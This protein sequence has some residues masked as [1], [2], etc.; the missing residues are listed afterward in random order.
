VGL[1]LLAIVV[2]IR[3]PRGLWGWIS[4]KHDLHFFPVQRRLVLPPD[5]GTDQ[6][7]N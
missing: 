4:N 5:M 1:G 2:T 3:F 6:R 7:R